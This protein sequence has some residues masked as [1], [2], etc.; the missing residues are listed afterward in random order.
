MGFLYI[1]GGIFNVVGEVIV[2]DRGEDGVVVV[3]LYIEKGFMGY[4]LK[5]FDIVGEFNLFEF[6]VFFLFFMEVLFEFLLCGMIGG[7]LF[8]LLNILFFNELLFLFLLECI[9]DVGEFCFDFLELE[10]VEVLLRNLE[11]CFK[12]IFGLEDKFKVVFV[13][14]VIS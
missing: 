14:L 3:I 9:E 7:L 10:W 11:V 8:F 1:V 2:G 6:L 13:I 5:G 4:I 12:F